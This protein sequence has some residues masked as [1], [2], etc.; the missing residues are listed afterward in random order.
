M[1]ERW[2]DIPGFG[3]KYQ[4]S[5]FGNVGSWA[6][7]GHEGVRRGERRLLRPDQH[8]NG[9][10][11]ATLFHKGRTVR[12]PVHR[13]VLEAF[14]GPSNGLICNHKDL[15]K[16]NNRRS[17]LEWTTKAGNARHAIAAGKYKNRVHRISKTRFKQL[18]PDRASQ[19]RE[20]YVRGG[21]TKKSLAAMFGVHPNT[22][23]RVTNGHTWKSAT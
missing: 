21:I 3:G 1:Q 15:N 7:P 4:I 23:K 10:L 13:L 9:Y 19:V 12:R 18:G 22:I 20:L 11:W 14:V 2:K 6:V 17:N 5:N 16:K 8:Q